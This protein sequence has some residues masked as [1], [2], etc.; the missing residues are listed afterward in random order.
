MLIRAAPWLRSASADVTMLDGMG[1]SLRVLLVQHE[2][3]T[4]AAVCAEL[5]RA[6]FEVAS[7]RV[8]TEPTL[9]RALFMI[10]LYYALIYLPLV[11]TFV[12]A[13]ALYGNEYLANSDT[14]ISNTVIRVGSRKYARIA[15]FKKRYCAR[16]A[17]AR[18]VISNGTEP[19]PEMKRGRTEVT[20]QGG[21]DTGLIPESLCSWSLF[22][23][24]PGLSRV[25][26]PAASEYWRI[27]ASAASRAGNRHSY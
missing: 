1:D 9:R 25:N 15:A 13:R 16:P 7:R 10:S 14:I 4:A 20:A 6:G 26:R 8:Q 24:S 21:P 5:D 17:S 23:C 19:S 11:V 22:G 27:S 18:K 12:C 2:A 3:S